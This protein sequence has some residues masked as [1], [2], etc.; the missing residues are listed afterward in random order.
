MLPRMMKM[1][2]GRRLGGEK[3]LHY[4]QLTPDIKRNFDVQLVPYLWEKTAPDFLK[5]N[6]DA[7]YY[8]KD[9]KATVVGI[10][11]VCRGVD[12]GVIG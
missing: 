5:L 6:I 7:S 11:R 1:L 8:K 12:Y 3:L 4:K 2:L 10:L 9:Y